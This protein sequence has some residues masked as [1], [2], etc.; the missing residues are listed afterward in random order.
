MVTRVCALYWP[1]TAAHHSVHLILFQTSLAFLA[2]VERPGG[3]ADSLDALSKL[4]G[5]RSLVE[6]TPPQP[7]V[8][9]A[10]R[11]RAGDVDILPA[12]GRVDVVAQETGRRIES[13][14]SGFDEPSLCSRQES[15]TELGPEIGRASCRERE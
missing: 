6:G 15:G 13:R 14:S 7:P 11:L 10:G 1:V 9:E 4:L 3:I 5:E 12:S 8:S 2:H